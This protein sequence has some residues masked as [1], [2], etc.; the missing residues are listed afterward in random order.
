MKVEI[1]YVAGCPNH[2]PTV[3][4]VHEMLALEGVLGELLE[5]EVR[6]V[7]DAQAIGFLGSPS[8]RIN[9]VDV[10][11]DARTVQ[12]FGLGCRIY[13]EGDRRS[14]MPSAAVIRRTIKAMQAAEQQQA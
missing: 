8:V 1:L 14:G 9:G 2:E 4:L 6:T 12:T 13:A 3:R 10:E 7:D 5:T 11:P